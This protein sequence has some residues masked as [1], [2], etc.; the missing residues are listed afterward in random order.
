MLSKYKENTDREFAPAYFH[1]TTE[2]VIGPKYS[3]KSLLEFLKRIDK[4]IS[5]GS[6]LIIESIDAK[7]V[8]ISI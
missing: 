8:N 3:L 1:S 2:I 6:G 5:E 7:Y 4:W